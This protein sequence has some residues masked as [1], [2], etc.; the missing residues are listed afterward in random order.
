M[1]ALDRL[2]WPIQHR[3]TLAGVHVLVRSTT[4]TGWESLLKHLPAGRP[5]APGWAADVTYSVT[6]A[7][8][9]HVLEP[10]NQYVVYRYPER[11]VR[12]KNMDLAWKAMQSDIT[13]IVAWYAPR[14]SIYHAGA[15]TWQDSGIILPG[16]SGTGKSTLTAA[17]L[18]LGATYYSDETAALDSRAWLHPWVKPLWLQLEGEPYMGPKQLV[19]PA[20]L[21]ARIGKRP[22]PVRVVAFPE[23]RA[24][25]RFHVE[26]IPRSAAVLALINYSLTS[27]RWPAR[28]LSHATKLVQNAICAHIRYPDAHYAAQRLLSLCESGTIG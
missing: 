13:A 1:K 11:I 3:F 6:P 18:E 17:L 22:R 7:G 26:E 25:S 14:W 5:P 23:W 28:T 27:M 24:G 9:P 4:D 12:S 10:L 8:G 20:G 15:V 16:P 2:D 21:G 19:Q